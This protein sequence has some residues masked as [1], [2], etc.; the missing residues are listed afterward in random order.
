MRNIIKKFKIWV[1]KK[2]VRSCE[3]TLIELNGKSEEYYKKIMNLIK[4]GGSQIKIAK[5]K[6][7][8]LGIHDMK[9]DMIDKKY[10]LRD[11][12]IDLKGAL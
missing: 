1:V 6:F 8:R 10:K 4:N 2:Q 5:L 3:L 12:L 9:M 7:E 11:R